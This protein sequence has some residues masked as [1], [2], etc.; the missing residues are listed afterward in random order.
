MSSASLTP[1][2]AAASPGASS[3]VSWW[4]R[5][6]LGEGEG[7]RWEIGPLTLA[8]E[9]R[10]REWRVSWAAGDPQADSSLRLDVRCPLPA[11]ELPA[12]SRTARFAAQATTP[13]LLL[14]PVLPDRAVVARPEQP[15]E[16]LAGEEVPLF[17]AVPVGVRLRVGGDRQL[18]E[19]PTQRLAD[20][21]FGPSTLVGELCYATRTSARLQPGRLPPRPHLA[22]CR[23]TLHNHAA[24][25]LPLERLALPVHHLDLWWHRER[26]LWTRGLEVERAA[27]G[28]LASLRLAD[29]P[30][31]LV[32]GAQRVAP[33]R[34]PEP[35]LGL[36][37]AL[38]ALLG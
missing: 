30:P 3:A 26:G 37:R 11:G 24:T 9:R 28:K 15:L 7:G 33:A 29:G 23:V 22:T 1:A 27:D 10:A 35:R 2:T 20:T 25:P 16:L 12:G 4:G 13:E 18:I 8:V 31:D 19:V 17:V 38:E 34:H 32:S 21:W 36:V 6:T 5:F 14:E